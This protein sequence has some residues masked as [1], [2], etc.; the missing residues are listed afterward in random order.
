MKGSLI[1]GENKA[2]FC[3]E[4]HKW[5]K[6]LD[7]LL[8]EFADIVEDDYSDY[9][10]QQND[11]GH[12]RNCEKTDLSGKYISSDRYKEGTL[13][14]VGISFPTLCPNASSF[15]VAMTL[16]LGGYMGIQF[17]WNIG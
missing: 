13:G 2:A 14:S 15:W 5:C 17:W 8:L 10:Q 4:G 3:R 12:H 7:S 16:T 1:L 11:Y 6:E 9:R